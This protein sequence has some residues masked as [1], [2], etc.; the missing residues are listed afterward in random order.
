M[1][2][3]ALLA[4]L[5]LL[6]AVA[7]GTASAGVGGDPVRVYLAGEPRAAEAGRDFVGEIIIEA[8]ADVFL[9]D[10]T[11]NGRGWTARPETPRA[12]YTLYSGQK[13]NYRFSAVPSDP[14]RPL[15]LSWLQD[16]VERRKIF[17]LSQ[18]AYADARL[19]MARVFAPGKSLAQGGGRLPGWTPSPGLRDARPRERQFTDAGAAASRRTIQVEG[20]VYLFHYVVADGDTTYYPVPCRDFQVVVNGHYFDLQFGDIWYEMGLGYTDDGGHFSI[21]ADWY[22]A[23]NPDIQVVYNA[24]THEAKVIHRDFD[25]NVWGIKSEIH[26]DVS[27]SSLDLGTFIPDTQ[28]RNRAFF[29]AETITRGAEYL[30]D[31]HG[32]GIDIVEVQWPELGDVSWFNPVFGQIHIIHASGWRESSILHEYGHYWNEEG[33]GFKHGWELGWYCNGNC[34]DEVA[35]WFDDCGHCVWCEETGKVTWNEGMANL[36]SVVCTDH[37][38]QAYGHLSPVVFPY[39]F[40]T[41]D[42][43]CDGLQDPDLTEGIFSAVLYDLIDAADDP[44]DDPAYPGYA[45]LIGGLESEVFEV[46]CENCPRY[47]GR[48]QYPMWFLYCFKDRY[49]EY[50]EDV[51]EAAMNNG[52][53]I[54]EARPG[55]PTY[56][57]S[58]PAPGTS[59]PDNTIWVQWDA[60]PDDASGIAGYDINWSQDGSGPLTTMDV[61]DVVGVESDPLEPGTW[62]LTVRALDRAGNWDLEWA[63]FGP[64]TV[65]EATGADLEY[66]YKTNWDYPLVPRNDDAAAPGDVT[67]S[68]YLAGGDTT[69]Y[70]NTLGINDGDIPVN[71]T[72]TAAQVDG[73]VVDTTSWPYLGPGAQ[74]LKINQGPIRVEGGRHIIGSRLDHGETV[75]ET[76]ESDNHYAGQFVWRPSLTATNSSQQLPAPPPLSGGFDYFRFDQ[77]LGF[78]CYGMDLDSYPSFQAVYMYAVDWGVDYDLKLYDNYA[79]PEN[80]F[81]SAL[82][83][84]SRPANCLDSIVINGYNAGVVDYNLGI[85][86]R[87]YDGTWA[88]SDF[89]IRAMPAGNIGYTYGPYVSH[90]TASM[91]VVIYMFVPDAA[92]GGHVTFTLSTLGSWEAPVH[93]GCF[94]AGFSLGGLLSADQIEVATRDE[95]AVIHATASLTE[96]SAVAV[97]LDMEGDLDTGVSVVLNYAPRRCDLETVTPDGWAEPLVPHP[98]ASVPY[99]Y[100]VVSEPGHLTGNAASTRFYLCPTNTGQAPVLSTFPAA[101]GLDGEEIAR[102]NM[103]ALATGAEYRFRSPAFE[104]QGGLH[105]LDLS[106][107]PDEAIV[108]HMETNNIH[109]RQ[110]AWSPASVSLGEIHPVV[111][112]STTGGHAGLSSSPVYN[113]AGFRSELLEP[114]EGRYAAAAVHGTPDQSLV[115]RIFPVD[116][117]PQTAFRRYDAQS[118]S[119]RGTIDYALV[120]L[121]RAGARE[122]D[123]GASRYEGCDT[124]TAFVSVAQSDGSTLV[125]GING[126]FMASA[127]WLLDVH[128]LTLTPGEWEIRLS[129]V[130]EDVDFAMALHGFDTFYSVTL[131]ARHYGVS[132]SGPQGTNEVIVY[133]TTEAIDLALVV[134]KSSRDHVI[135]WDDSYT[136]EITDTST[137]IDHGPPAVTRLLEPAPNPFNPQTRIAFDLAETEPVSVR[138]YD[139]RGA[140]VRTLHEGGLA[141]GRHT[142]R[143]DGRDDAGRMLNSAAY[144]LRFR[145]GNVDATRKLTLVR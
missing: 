82:A 32:F 93:L 75:A 142:L 7:A 18:A 119:A 90:L 134:W 102:Y 29:I 26:P 136:V 67:V 53:D 127:E 78:N 27:A 45:D 58:T 60:A 108:E 129:E 62:Y 105:T 43:Q 125:A 61:G 66:A 141:A 101:I 140:V 24:Q 116:D 95:P 37:I 85:E 94:D 9:S 77:P 131:D 25:E 34:D 110:W 145:A 115:L 5:P 91:M 123:I 120:D 104:I 54:D 130:N 103:P 56:V 38:D 11:L 12:S 64:W 59:G 74:G 65:V 144:F 109:A 16:G 113:C 72:E 88:D 19:G 70:W 21:D 99:P 138:V 126:P 63:T 36:I 96:Y 92:S 83:V 97:W 39:D 41:I 35:Y 114:A 117:D 80:G 68:S 55:V 76:N 128:E 52:Y 132:D 42:S 86:N 44:E 20:D 124:C 79:T 89:R 33:N 15:V 98:D 100:G 118:A 133:E 1:K 28:K 139:L 106:L 112:P 121:Q 111:P 3:R 14:D 143:W 107:D 51:W 22:F 2:T 46:V 57:S 13:A 23:E 48:P 30:Q 69:T 50:A 49:P 4:I 31:T 71:T 87:T 122:L 40:R 47:G 137:G 10:M 17:D 135:G 81:F 8:G 84:S 6:C 73:V